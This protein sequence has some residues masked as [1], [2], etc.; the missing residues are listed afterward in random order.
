MVKFF[1]FLLFPCILFAEAPWGTASAFSKKPPT[2]VSTSPLHY[3]ILFH[4][5]AL[6]EADGPRSHFYPTSSEYARQ[7]VCKFGTG[8][9]FFLSCDRLLRE[10]SEAWLYRRTCLK[11]GHITK[12]DPVPK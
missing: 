9:G 4:Q 7:A 2:L 1:L 3:I 8:V 5:Q 6:S 11:S 10:N 12:F